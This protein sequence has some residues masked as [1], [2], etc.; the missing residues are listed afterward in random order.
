MVRV[1]VLHMTFTRNGSMMHLHHAMSVL[2][3]PNV[4]NGNIRM[5]RMFLRRMIR[6]QVLQSLARCRPEWTSTIQSQLNQFSD[7]H[8]RNME[9]PISH[10]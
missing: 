1:I 8:P 9:A 2:M 6:M 3:V 5:L 7:T 4:N 10:Y